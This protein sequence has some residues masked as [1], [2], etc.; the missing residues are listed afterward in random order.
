M[1]LPA[2]MVRFTILSVLL[3]LDDGKKWRVALERRWIPRELLDWLRL[4]SLDGLG[5]SCRAGWVP[6][7]IT[8]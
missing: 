5:E 2:V 4:E 8:V 1:R 7:D 3:R 6:Q